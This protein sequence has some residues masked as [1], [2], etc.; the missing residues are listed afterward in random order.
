MRVLL[1]RVGL[2][3]TT[4]S[5]CLTNRPV[6]S[7]RHG[8]KRALF[9]ETFDDCWNRILTAVCR[10]WCLTDE[11]ERRTEISVAVQVP[12]LKAALMLTRPGSTWIHSVFSSFLNRLFLW[13]FSVENCGTVLNLPNW[14][15]ALEPLFAMMHYINWHLHLQSCNSPV[16]CSQSTVM[17]SSFIACWFVHL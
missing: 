16:L 11:S 7:P 8:T 12:H 14:P 4:G 3:T 5:F 9:T 2:I 6:F 10:L 17:V 15:E 1:S 13:F